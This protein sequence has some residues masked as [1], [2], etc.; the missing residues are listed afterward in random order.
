MSGFDYVAMG[1]IHKPEIDEKMKMAYSGSLE[2]IDM[3][4]IDLEAIFMGRFQREVLNLNLCLC[5][6]NL[7]GT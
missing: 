6:E 7:Q 1:H 4:D 2:P 5:K 3:N